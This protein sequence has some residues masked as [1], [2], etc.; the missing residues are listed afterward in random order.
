VLSLSKDEA[1]A[2]LCNDLPQKN[3]IKPLY[4]SGYLRRTKFLIGDPA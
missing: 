2:M 4:V 3:G 1:I